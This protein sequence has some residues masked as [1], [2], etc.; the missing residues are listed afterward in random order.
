MLLRLLTAAIVLS[1]ALAFAQT[2]S[3]S[4]KNWSG[5]YAGVIGGVTIDRAATQTSVASAGAYF[6]V[7]DPAQIAAAGRGKIKID[8]PI[9]GFR[10]GFDW[11]RHHFLVGA[12]VDVSRHSF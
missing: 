2:S 4:S 9:G 10:G 11:Q 5:V 6:V 1:P 7:S 12:S 8:N 3:V